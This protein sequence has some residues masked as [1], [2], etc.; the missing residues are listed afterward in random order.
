[1][2]CGRRGTKGRGQMYTYGRCVLMYGKKPSQ[3]CKVIIQQLKVKC[4]CVCTYVD[5]YTHTSTL[6]FKNYLSRQ[7]STGKNIPQRRKYLAVSKAV[8]GGRELPSNHKQGLNMYIGFG[9]C[10]HQQSEQDES[11][12]HGEGRRR[13]RAW[14]GREIIN[15]GTSSRNVT[16]K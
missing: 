1:M 5:M 16:Y 8:W 9:V 10:S 11:Q 14:N 7:K 4:V 15:V 3:Y 13:R 2:C 12:C 6:V